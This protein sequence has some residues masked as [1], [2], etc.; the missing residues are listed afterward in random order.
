M[1][2]LTTVATAK[3]CICLLCSI[4]FRIGTLF[5]N[6][7][8]HSY[9]RKISSSLLLSILITIK[10]SKKSNMVKVSDNT[11]LLKSRGSETAVYM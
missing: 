11:A 9:S 1:R 6:E 2:T 10:L 4:V 3:C 5:N 8:W 7:E